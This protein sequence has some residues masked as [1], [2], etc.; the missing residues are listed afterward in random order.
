MPTSSEIKDPKR[1][2]FAS[3]EE[4]SLFVDWVLADIA[5][6]P[7]RGKNPADPI[8]GVYIEYGPDPH[9][10]KRGKSGIRKGPAHMRGSDIVARRYV[11]VVALQE[12]GRSL[13]EACAEVAIRLHG[14]AASLEKD[15][16][17]KTGF[18]KCRNKP[19]RDSWFPN[20]V[21]MFNDW[22]NWEIKENLFDKG[23]PF[24]DLEDSMRGHAEKMLGD[25]WKAMRFSKRWQKLALRAVK[26]LAPRIEKERSQWAD[27]AT[28]K[29]QSFSEKT[30][31]GRPSSTLGTATESGTG[32]QSMGPPARKSQ[33]N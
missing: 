20:W 29:D 28:V 24:E 4:L 12:P 14:A 21:T 8:R 16:S 33:T 31:D 17:I 15:Q 13:K 7:S 2:R 32:S 6:R 22:L 25:H 26:L 1:T 11:A 18:E 27:A 3:E 10:N 19:F 23:I 30:G 5:E 9:P